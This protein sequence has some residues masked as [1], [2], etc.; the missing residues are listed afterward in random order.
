[1]HD[2]EVFAYLS[3][4]IALTD[5]LVSV[6]TGGTNV[7]A[8]KP[9]PI[10]GS[11]VGTKRAFQVGLS[12]RPTNPPSASLNLGGALGF[13]YPVSRWYRAARR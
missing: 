3:A 10:A 11:P 7:L 6:G 5:S 2:S 9:R 12:S 1:M 4:N 8:A 13:S